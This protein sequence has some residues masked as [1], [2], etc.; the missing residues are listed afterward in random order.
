MA[1]SIH[2]AVIGDDGLYISSRTAWG[3]DLLYID[4]QGHAT[5]LRQQVGSFETWGVPSPDGKHLA[6]LEWTGAGKVWMLKGF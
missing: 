6:L 5:V 4:M 1:L 2:S 3:A